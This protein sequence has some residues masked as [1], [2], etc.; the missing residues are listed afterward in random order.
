MKKT[1]LIVAFLICLVACKDKKKDTSEFVSEKKQERPVVYVSNYP[2][3]YFAEKIGAEAIDLR[4]PASEET[5]PSGW[6]AGTETILDMQQADLILINGATFERWMN[7]V[8][9]PD[10][11]IVNTTRGLNDRLVPLGEQFTHSHGEGGEHTHE[12]TASITWLDLSLAI[13]Q[14]EKVKEALQE[15][16]PGKSEE[17]QGNFQNLKQSLTELDQN[18]KT[19]KIDPEKFQLIYSHPVYQYLQSAY[20]LEGESLHWEPG[21]AWNKDKKHEIE[22]LAKKGKKT[23]LIW[24]DEPNKETKEALE[25]MGVHSIVVNPLFGQPKHIDFSEALLTNLQNLQKITE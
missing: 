13:A 14:A 24:E 17:I 22:H 12:G 15:I 18:Y 8:S 25:A 7:N 6:I 1:S 4:F 19:L 10:D 16:V 2:L 5:D 20:S 21:D 23:Y 9:L 11:I 3:Y